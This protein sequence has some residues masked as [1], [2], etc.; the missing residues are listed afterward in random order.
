MTGI[1]SCL[2]NSASVELEKAL[3]EI[4]KIVYHRLVDIVKMVHL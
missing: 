3:G 1:K 2:E 4:S